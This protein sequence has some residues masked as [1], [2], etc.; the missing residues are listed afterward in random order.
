MLEPRTVK[1]A[2]GR[3]LMRE[4]TKCFEKV[5]IVSNVLKQF[6]VDTWDPLSPLNE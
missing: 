1:M 2:W 3:L 4:K 5:L 6:K